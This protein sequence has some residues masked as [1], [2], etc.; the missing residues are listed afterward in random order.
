LREGNDLVEPLY[1]IKVACS[2]CE[3][4]F[5]TSKVRPS[6]KKTVK[7]DTDFCPYYKDYNPEFYTVR[8]CPYCGF[9][10]TELFSQKLAD[11]HK[12][13]FAEK[14]GLHWK[15]FDYGKERIWGEAM[16]TYK[17]AVVCAQLAEEKDRVMAALLQRVAWLY[18]Y[19][20]REEE[21]QRFLRHALECYIKVYELEGIDL[22]NAKLMYMIGELHRRIHNYAE[23]VKWFS[24]VINDKKIQD[25]AMIRAC[26]EQWA[27][28]RENMG[29]EGVE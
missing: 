26:R 20:G 13:A 16:H 17:L 25:A 23:A 15:R 22:N 1:Q 8:V 11:K 21:E 24:R 14:I 3:A 29:E 10:S 28:A 9:S 12:E 2:C 27:A 4:E 7:T 18:R 6:F 19:R 5:I